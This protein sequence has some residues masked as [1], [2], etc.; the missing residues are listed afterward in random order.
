MS[1]GFGRLPVQNAD[2]NP[3][4]P[5]GDSIRMR[6]RARRG[7]EA[8]I[9]APIRNRL[10]ALRPYKGSNPFLSAIYKQ[11]PSREGFCVLADKRA[12]SFGAPLHRNRAQSQRSFAG[13]QFVA[14][15][16]SRVMWLW[17]AKP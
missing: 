4:L 17:S 8:V 11:K 10:R 6:A 15:M 14:R 7:T 16:N 5:G 12:F 9:T 3:F 13:D 2:A 1:G